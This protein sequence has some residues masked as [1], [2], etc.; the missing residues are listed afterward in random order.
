MFEL[1]KPEGKQ[2]VATKAPCCITKRVTTSI[3]S[4]KKK[5]ATT[6]L[7]IIV[8]QYLEDER[9]RVHFQTE[10]NTKERVK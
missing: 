6:A 2:L 1:G 3:K 9:Y 4:A 7:L 8:D 10:S 5:R